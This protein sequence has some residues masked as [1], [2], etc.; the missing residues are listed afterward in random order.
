[1]A[2]NEIKSGWIEKRSQ[3]LK[4]WRERWLVLSPLFLQTYKTPTDQEHATMSLEL[5]TIDEAVPSEFEI[6]KEHCFRITAQGTRYYIATDTDQEMCSWLNIINHARHIQS[7]PLLSINCM[8]E[9]KATSEVCLIA[10]FSKI[11]ELLHEREEEM[12]NELEEC[13]RNYIEKV[14]QELS[15]LTQTLDVENEN[16]R[17]FTEI[18]KKEDSLINKIRKIQAG[19]RNNLSFKEFDSL[20]CSTLSV[21]I[22][23]EVL[24]N[25]I[26]F[27]TRVS[28]VN[29]MEVSIRRTN[30]TRA[31]KWRYTGERIDALTFMVSSDVKLTGVGI[32]APY[33]QGGSVTVK[34]FQIVKGK[35]TNSSSVYKNPSR[36]NITYSPENSVTKVPVVGG[37]K[38]KKFAWYSV[39]F[40]IEGDH[41]YKCVD[42]S[43]KVQG[44]GDVEWEFTN[45]SFHQSHQNNRCDTVCGPIADFYYMQLQKNDM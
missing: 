7:V 24:K 37:L 13:Q 17:Y 33:K 5:S 26:N 45:T 43:Q 21:S 9:K 35:Y 31:L 23:E 2:G 14:E 27:S 3:Y 1:M 12:V 36:I 8:Q 19:R 44:P 39:I 15:E 6:A 16:Y 25:L 41:T 22:K 29:P 4:S 18:Y 10:T 20:N 38:I 28:L 42:C 30:I 40:C 32:C 11:K 34:D